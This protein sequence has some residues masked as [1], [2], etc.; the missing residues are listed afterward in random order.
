VLIIMTLKMVLYGICDV[1][2]RI[3]IVNSSGQC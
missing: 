3:R 2:A 1:W